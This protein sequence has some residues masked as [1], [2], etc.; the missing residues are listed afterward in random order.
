M[1]FGLIV[2]FQMASEMRMCSFIAFVLVLFFWGPP[3]L[4][5]F[6]A[7]KADTLFAWSLGMPKKTRLWAALDSKSKDF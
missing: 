2:L 3:E 1:L 7:Q 4:Y 5:N 6:I